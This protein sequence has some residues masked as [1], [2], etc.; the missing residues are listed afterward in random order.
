M[1]LSI[2]NFYGL[3]LDLLIILLFLFLLFC[4]QSQKGQ[5]SQNLEYK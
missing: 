4:V 3:Y 5:T 2:M 1:I